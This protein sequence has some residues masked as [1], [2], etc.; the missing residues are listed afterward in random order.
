M[1]YAEELRTKRRT[2]PNR[3]TDSCFDKACVPLRPGKHDPTKLEFDSIWHIIDIFEKYPRK[4]SSRWI[5][6]EN[7]EPR[8]SMNTNVDTMIRLYKE[9][10]SEGIA[11]VEKQVQEVQQAAI[12]AIQEGEGF[13]RS[14]AGSMVN[15]DAFLLGEPDNM[16]EFTAAPKEVLSL[17]IKLDAFFSGF[18]NAEEIINRGIIIGAI[19]MALN[20]LGVFVT[21]DSVAKY[22]G[23]GGGRASKKLNKEEKSEMLVPIM[24]SGRIENLSDAL[25]SIAHP[26]TTRNLYYS[27]N[28]ICGGLDGGCLNGMTTD[29]YKIVPGSG[30][31]TIPGGWPKHADLEGSSW[32]SP[33]AAK[34]ILKV[35]FSCMKRT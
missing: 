20:R 1:N 34:K 35:L 23:I 25:L 17:H 2:I 4:V 24:K 16:F 11:A 7:S 33:D 18:I 12:S 32:A 15:I 26:G 28:A 14:Y 5:D 13:E 22:T 27:I 9:G 8:W 29:D 21:L 10:W 3:E 30:Q 19:T 31:I 6:G